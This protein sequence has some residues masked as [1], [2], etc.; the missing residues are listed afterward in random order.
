MTP[1]QIAQT[2]L[3]TVEGPGPENNPTILKMYASIGQ[4]H[5]EHDSVAWC[6]AF[7]GHCLEEAGLQSTRKLT[8]RSYL[9]WGIEVDLSEAQEGDLAVFSRRKASS[10]QGHVGFIRKIEGKFL[11]ILGGNQGD[12][13]SI[14]RYPAA[15]LLGIRRAGQVTPK[16]TCSILDV[17]TRLRA[18]GYYEVGVADGVMGPRTR[19]GILA[20][21]ADRSL[22]LVPLIDTELCNALRHAPPRSVDLDRKTG[23]PRESRILKSA[24]QQMGLGLVGSFSSLLMLLEPLVSNLET[25]QGL[26]ARTLSLLRE[27]PGSQFIPAALLFAL[28]VCMLRLAFKTRAARLDDHRTGKTP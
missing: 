5:I 14:G 19:A 18:L 4:S 23:A 22:D 27:I 17:Q 28:C 20:F 26:M 1:Y 15:R 16:A 6:A 25:A 8:A 2:Y 9:T 21:R 3:G 7:V 11:Y 12:A 13:V 24:N 10:W